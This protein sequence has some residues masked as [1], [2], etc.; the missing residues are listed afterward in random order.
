MT[1]TKYDALQ[2]IRLAFDDTNKAL[3]VSGSVSVVNPFTS[4]GYQDFP[5]GTIT[6]TSVTITANSNGTGYTFDSSKVI[7][8]Q[9]YICLAANN[10]AVPFTGTTTWFSSR[11]KVTGVSGDVATLNGVPNAS[12]GDVRIWYLYRY[13]NG[14][15]T[16][17]QVAPEFI[18]N[19]D[20][21]DSLYLSSI[22]EDTN[23]TLG[24]N[25]NTAGYS[26]SDSTG[27][28]HINDDLVIN[29]SLTFNAAS[30]SLVLP[31][32]R[33]TSGQVLKTNGDG[34]TVWIDPPASGVTSITA[35]TGLTGGTITS[36][37]TIALDTTTVTAGS[38]TSANITVDAYGRITS[39]SNGSGGGGSDETALL[40]SL[41]FGG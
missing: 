20:Q 3:R 2:C 37:G 18:G 27:S 41:V 32:S 1:I 36:T 10:E 24:A 9:G 13:E 11:V 34:T 16:N 7:T 35:G 12:W 40:Y 33:G 14:I 26:I 28:V 31:T 30:N 22:V 23:P 38:Y 19:L 25:L 15:P 4:W 39:A 29:G 17:Y 6:G 8:G 21:L 5:A